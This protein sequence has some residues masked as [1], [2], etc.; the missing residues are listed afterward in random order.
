MAEKPKAPRNWFDV[1]D[2]VCADMTIRPGYQWECPRGCYEFWE[3]MER[4]EQRDM[5]AA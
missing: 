4:K 3:E 2:H 1:T 5:G